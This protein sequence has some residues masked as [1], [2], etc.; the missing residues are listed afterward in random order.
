MVCPFECLG[1][2]GE[3]I[4][5]EPG[6]GDFA[7]VFVAGGGVELAEPAFVFPGGRADVNA[8]VAGD[9]GEQI[10]GFGAVERFSHGGMVCG[11]AGRVNDGQADSGLRS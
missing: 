9:A 5:L 10:G 1:I 8:M 2:F 6:G 4:A 3:A 11:R 7:A